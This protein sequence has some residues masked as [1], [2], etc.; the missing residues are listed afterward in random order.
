M[1][2][3]ERVG[4]AGLA[5]W[6]ARAALPFF[7]LVEAEAGRFALWLPVF[8]GI[9]DI[10][11][12]SL[13]AEPPLWAGAAVAGLALAIFLLL[14]GFSLARLLP[15][16]LFVTAL[17][18][19]A[20]QFATFRAPP[21]LELPRRAVML[22]G[23]V[24]AIEGLPEGSRVVLDGV[25]L[26]DGPALPRR[27]RIRLRHEEAENF[28][29]GETLALRALLM[30][31]PPPAYPGAWD[32]ER[33]DFFHALGGYG[34]A[35]GPVRRIA[36][37]PAPGI[38]A[39]IEA[40]RASIAAQV[41]AALPDAR[42]AIAAT[43]LSGFSAAIPE[44]DRAAFRDAGLAHLLA[45]AGLHIGIVMGLVLG[46]TRLLLAAFE[47]PALHW[48]ARQIA[49]LT[50]LAAGGFY[51][52]LTGAHVPI[53]RSFAMAAL[54]TLGLLVGR[55][56]LSLR[57]L[58]LAAAAVILSAPEEIEGV[59]FQMSFS[60]VLALV[61][62][63]EALWPWLLGI[64]ARWRRHLVMLALTSLLAG[65][66]S[67]PF[68][69]AHFGRV[70]IYFV[71]ANLLA[72]PVTAFWVMPFGLIALALMPFRLEFLALAP[73]GWG[74]GVILW[75]ARTVSALPA[76]TLA[77]AHIPPWGL[78]LFALGIAWLGIWR[79]RLRLGGVAILAL[80]LLSPL[81]TTP[82]DILVS[83]DA[84]L[85]ALRTRDA[86]YI[87]ARAGASRFTEDAWAEYWAKG[88]LRPRSEA[89][90]NLVACDETTCRVR[91]RAQDAWA[92]L[93]PRGAAREDAPEPSDAAPDLAKTDLAAPA[94]AAPAP[95]P[96]ADCDVALVISPEPLHG[97]CPGIAHIDRFTVWREGAA[98][99]WLGPRDARVLTEQA[100]RGARPWVP[101]PPAARHAAPHPALPLAAE[102]EAPPR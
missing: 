67:A 21:L 62:G 1:D 49:A 39:V 56:A 9:G 82:P 81:L 80:A 101:L 24:T 19:G 12:F 64:T 85:I 96:G 37:P 68:A 4:R 33:D 77:V 10:F 72:V 48:P 58:A 98:A 29:I 20:A 71:L 8:L 30:P 34:T 66:A 57:G 74:I 27:L 32:L 7:A 51:L 3:V 53:R 79:S 87:L 40:L 11:Y 63:Y 35:L 18:F 90:E 92:L 73:M 15:F 38:E 91:P 5:E 17:G 70:Q 6:T 47:W 59:S 78:A 42:G 83:A 60:A 23:R 55:R 89:P 94:R 95:T 88:A 76:A 26:N 75:I 13:R 2:W 25:R 14:R 44:A 84:R 65:T 99:V 43:L 93:V 50:A 54:V 100:W 36:G 31:P 69:A 16:L 97:R 86:A 102:D 22:S 41:T 46:F 45:I 28:A 61:S 52:L